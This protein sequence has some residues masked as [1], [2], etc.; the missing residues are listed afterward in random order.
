MARVARRC[1]PFTLLDG[2]ILVAATAAGFALW[3]WLFL[4]QLDATRNHA[5]AP[6]RFGSTFF[7]LYLSAAPIVLVQMI[8]FVFLRARQ[9]RHSW[10]RMMCQPGLAGCVAALGFLICGATL[11][12]PLL[13]KAYPM[14]PVGLLGAFLPSAV[15]SA[16]AVAWLLLALGRRWRHERGWID[17]IGVILGC[18]WLWA[19][20]AINYYGASAVV[21][22]WAP[23][24]PARPGGSRL[25]EMPAK[26]LLPLRPNPSVTPMRPLPPRRP[27][28]AFPQPRAGGA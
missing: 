5:A 3:R 23:R 9:P 18:Y 28:V 26:S 27:S 16:V 17:G 22:V 25:I 10:R 12:R 20:L 11:A 15:G 21:D 7:S 8:G 24:A 4:D 13:G 6:D 2:M 14:L 19:A 1:R